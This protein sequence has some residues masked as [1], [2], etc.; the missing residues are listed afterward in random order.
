MKSVDLVVS[1][2]PFSFLGKRNLQFFVQSVCKI[3]SFIFSLVIETI[4]WRIEKVEALGEIE[5][6]TKLLEDDIVV[7]VFPTA[8]YNWFDRMISWILLDHHY[9]NIAYVLHFL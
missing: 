6:A 4:L 3:W 9:K 2:E 8:L 5:V 1:Y 7:Q